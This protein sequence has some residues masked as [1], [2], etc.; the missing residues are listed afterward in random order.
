LFFHEVHGIIVLV[1]YV[2]ILFR[3]TVIFAGRAPPRRSLVRLFLV[4]V[5]V[6]VIIFGLCAQES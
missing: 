1:V 4:V 6:V 3:I 5:V 2:G